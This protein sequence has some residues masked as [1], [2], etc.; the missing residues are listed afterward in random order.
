MFVARLS[1]AATRIRR[2][3]ETSPLPADA[4]LLDRRAFANSYA[5]LK[6]TDACAVVQRLAVHT[7]I[8]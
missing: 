4:K 5:R 2:I 3:H 7:S 1:N 8:H 6:S